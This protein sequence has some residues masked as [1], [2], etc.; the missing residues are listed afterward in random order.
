M[1]CVIL[2]FKDFNSTITVVYDI[3]ISVF[4]NCTSNVRFTFAHLDHLSSVVFNENV[5]EA[6]NNVDQQNF[7]FLLC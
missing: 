6:L 2:P 7:H 4:N 1:T 3:Y 5:F